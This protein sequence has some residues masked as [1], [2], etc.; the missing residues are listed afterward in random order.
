MT[1]VLASLD[2]LAATLSAPRGPGS[3]LSV[4]GPDRLDSEVQAAS[5]G[6]TIDRYIILGVLGVGGM[7]TV[8]SAHDPELDRKVAVKLLQRG[9]LTLAEQRNSVRREARALARLNHRNVVSVFDVGLHE[10][11]VF[12]AMEFIEGQTLRQWLDADGGTRSSAEILRVFTAAGAGLIAAHEAALVHRDFKPDNVMVERGGRVVVMDFGLARVP[13]VAK[14]E[15]RSGDSLLSGSAFPLRMMGT[16][17]YMAPEQ[18]LGDRPTAAIDQFAYCVALYEALH[19]AHPFHGDTPGER[20]ASVLSGRFNESPPKSPVRVPGWLE[21]ILRRGLSTHPAARYSSM[22]DLLADL[23]AG[24]RR[25]ARR[26]PLWL[27]GAVV[28]GLTGLGIYTELDARAA[29]AACTDAGAKIEDT[30]GP[31]TRDE[32]ER[33][34]AAS[35]VVYAP[36]T[37][38][39]TGRWLDQHASAWSSTATEVCLAATVDDKLGEDDAALARWCLD[40]NRSELRVLLE[41][42]THADEATV[43]TSVQS[44]ASLESPRRCLELRG[45]DSVAPRGARYPQARK[46]LRRARVLEQQG[47]HEQALGVLHQST[48]LVESEPSPFLIR[49]AQLEADVLSHLGRYELAAQKAREAYHHAALAGSWSAAASA[50]FTLA[51]IRGVSQQQ[52]TIGLEWVDHAAVAQSHARKQSSGALEGTLVGKRAETLGML[53]QKLERL[54]D[55][56]TMFEEAQR[57]F[58]ATLGPQH[59]TLGSVLNNRASVATDQLDFERAA[60]LYA[61]SLGLIRATLGPQHPNVAAVL[62]NLGGVY[63]QTGALDDAAHCYEESISLLESLD[64]HDGLALAKVATNLGSIQK[65]RGDYEAARRTY[66]R[67]LEIFRVRVGPESFETTVVLVNIGRLEAEAGDHAAAVEM[68]SSA[69]RIREAQL[70]NQHRKLVGPLLSLGRALAHERRRGEARA[71]LRRARELANLAGDEDQSGEAERELAALH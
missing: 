57:N 15:R 10:R 17:G 53:Y 5:P 6:E 19:D 7:G 43:R 34:F 18:I 22:A 69:V 4:I 63:G 36:Q 21:H 56:E 71:A 38:T 66:E 65:K 64:R 3:G 55:A 42:L 52:P 28:L 8:F 33:A 67:A 47:K 11:Q 23:D 70:G 26:G 31:H 49:A 62:N 27:V 12:L 39:L 59:P 13:S 9:H 45:P 16:P 20:A 24:Q 2:N 40:E 50:A 25:L 1:C 61:E 68:F 54:D 60:D 32:L 51:V 37:A 41:G 46:L 29:M 30:W 48:A 44:A 35:G 14:G 58:E